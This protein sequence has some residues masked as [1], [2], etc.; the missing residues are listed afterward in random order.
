[1]SLAVNVRVYNASRRVVLLYTYETWPLQP[2]VVQRF[3]V[4]DHRCF[5]RIAGIW[6]QY[7]V[8]NA[9]VQHRVFVYRDENPTSITILKDWL[10]WLGYA[11]RMSS[12]RFMYLV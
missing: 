2:E 10:L 7:R 11:F 6:W 5:G 3:F 1:M 8:S 9:E 4:V 12:R